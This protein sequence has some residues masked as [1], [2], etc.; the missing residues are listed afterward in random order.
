MSETAVGAVCFAWFMDENDSS[1]EDGA[2]ENAGPEVEFDEGFGDDATR[3]QT[4]IGAG[5][6]AAP[7]MTIP[8]GL[9]DKIAPPVIKIPSAL[10]DKIAPPRPTLE[11]LGLA[12]SARNIMRMLTSDSLGITSIMRGSGLTDS[13][14]SLLAA[15]VPTLKMRDV[16]RVL[17]DGMSA[18][19]SAML[20]DQAL[21]IADSL[22]SSVMNQFDSSIFK[23]F[24]SWLPDLASLRLHLPT[25]WRGVKVDV[26]EIEQDVFRILAEGIPLAWV[27][28]KRV[29]VLLLNAPDAQARRRVIS[30]N[31]RGIIGSCLNVA[32]SLPLS[33]RPLFLADM[34]VRA[35][36]ALQDG[37][38][39][40]AQ[41][42]ATNVLDTLLT[43]YSREALG[44]SKG[45][46][47][48][49]SYAEKLS[50][51]RSWGLQLALRPSFA[52]MRGEHTVHGRH[53][54]FHRNA[55]AHAVTSHQYSRIN[56][57]L[58]VMNATSVLACFARDTEAF[59]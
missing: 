48:N 34:I 42:L 2:G 51:D 19:F 21:G 1:A 24:P 35:V 39:E 4:H 46:I 52:L 15:Q 17:G 28:S 13:L 33:G 9:I 53:N 6:I 7:A 45:G 16:A 8:S 30:N 41:A 12:E 27:P 58:A 44:R 31:Y 22:T 32:G 57:V 49:P 3:A 37:H 56:A 59:D 23:L 38:I 54:G 47:L 25:N 50:K 40:A 36:R 26:D 18:K 29:I 11:S 10:I 55:T 5:Q 14:T 20:T 43:G